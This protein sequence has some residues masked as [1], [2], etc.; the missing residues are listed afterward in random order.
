MRI[1]AAAVLLVVALAGCS[2]SDSGAL[3]GQAARDQLTIILD[4]SIDAF[5][6]GGGSETTLAGDQQRAVI[7][8]PTAP[9]GQR[10]VAVDLADSDS[11]GFADESILALPSM[12][13]MA[14]TADFLAADA[15]QDGDTFRITGEAY[16]LDVRVNDGLVAQIDLTA[17]GGSS[18]QSILITYGVGAEA[19]RLFDAA[20]G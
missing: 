12:K 16:E 11:P 20:R 5:E 17:P 3:T 7:Y 18:A 19:R 1:R 10:V 8:D 9:A 13:G 4:A 6:S 15:S 2:A 14:A